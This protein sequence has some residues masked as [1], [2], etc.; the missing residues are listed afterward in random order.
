MNCSFCGKD[1]EGSCPER[2]RIMNKTV[3]MNLAKTDRPMCGICQRKTSTF[4]SKKFGHLCSDSCYEIAQRGNNPSVPHVVK[5]RKGDLHFMQGEIRFPVDYDLDKT[6]GAGMYGH[7]PSCL[8]KLMDSQVV[9]FAGLNNIPVDPFV[10][11]LVESPLRGIVQLTWYR[12]LNV[13]HDDAN[14]VKNQEIRIRDYKRNLAEYKPGE[15]GVGVKKNQRVSAKQEAMHK[16]FKTKPGHFKVASGRERQLF[17]VIYELSEKG[18]HPVPFP[19]IVESAEKKVKTKQNIEKIVV[20][21][22][23]VLLESGAVEETK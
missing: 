15:D 11:Y 6:L 9:T 20:R 3:K 2:I 8:D 14:L 13:Q 16:S 10:R 12:D 4:S 19:K 1:H 23:K 18:K 21:F 22:L 7:E 5:N 17:E